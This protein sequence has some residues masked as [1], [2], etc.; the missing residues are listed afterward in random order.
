MNNR[1]HKTRQRE[2]WLINASNIN[3]RKYI[4][5]TTQQRKGNV[6]K[7]PAFSNVGE[8]FN[9]CENMSR[10]DRS[11]ALFVLL[12]ATTPPIRFWAFRK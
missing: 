3:N 9:T 8:A 5:G 10:F 11:F 7:P 1:E 12:K 4:F 2:R 6:D